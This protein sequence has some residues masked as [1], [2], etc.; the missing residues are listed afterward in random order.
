MAVARTAH[1]WMAEK[2]FFHAGLAG[3]DVR[4]RFVAVESPE[5]VIT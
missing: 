4:R 5:S 3:G 2:V 1:G